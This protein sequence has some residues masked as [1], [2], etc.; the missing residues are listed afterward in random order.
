[1]ENGKPSYEALEQELNE[2]KDL[3]WQLSDEYRVNMGNIEKKLQEQT[4][5]MQQ[6]ENKTTIPVQENQYAYISSLGMPACVLDN[7]GGI[8]KY[9]NKFK[10]LVEL[11][12]F[13][14]EE[15]TNLSVLLA[16]DKIENL[17]EKAKEYFKSDDGVFQSLFKVENT[18]QGL[19][20][21]V[22]RI[23]KFDTGKEHLALFIE[24]HKLEIKGL[25]IEHKLQ[26]VEVPSAPPI[27]N[28][29]ENDELTQLKNEIAI[30]AEK[31]EVYTE[32]SGSF[33]GKDDSPAEWTESKLKEIT[34]IFN[35]EHS[36]NRIIEK[37]NFHYK[38]FLQIIR[39]KYP[40]L[41]PNEEK[42]CML[43][44][45]GLTYKEISAVMDISINGVKI[46]RNRLRKKLDLEND[47]KTS[48]FI[49]KV[50]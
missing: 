3:L 20:N 10:F 46:A 19:I 35:L 36:R 48:E 9:N 8:I 37:L 45:A 50:E 11:L 41:T 24:L 13:E 1:M 14:I 26:Q 4:L 12:G 31:Y 44:R 5:Q 16:K 49:D 38:E 43:I 18:F 22:L 2:Y 17:V 21:L 42:H 6:L 27:K 28:L 33:T 47:T 32:I 30:F 25:G 34:G 39:H 29:P 15:I 23:Y 40:D 7:M